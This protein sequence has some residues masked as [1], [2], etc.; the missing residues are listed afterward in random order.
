MAGRLIAFGLYGPLD[1]QLQMRT[2]PQRRN[3]VSD[4][5]LDLMCV[6][7]ER[8]DILNVYLHKKT[9][10]VTAVNIRSERIFYTT[11]CVTC[12]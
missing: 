11:L 7:I 3:V 4:W 10:M 9:D 1:E 6:Q 12:L 5:Q 8:E 2:G